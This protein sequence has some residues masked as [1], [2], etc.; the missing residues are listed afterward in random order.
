MICDVQILNKYL[1]WQRTFMVDGQI[2]LQLQNVT[3]VA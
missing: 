1:E 2:F 3:D